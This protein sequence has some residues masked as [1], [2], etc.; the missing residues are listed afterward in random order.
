MKSF[1][2]LVV[3]NLVYLCR[4]DEEKRI[5]QCG[6]NVVNVAGMLDVLYVYYC[7]YIIV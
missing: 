6:G 3:V 7:M 2:E 1:N 4:R 5:K